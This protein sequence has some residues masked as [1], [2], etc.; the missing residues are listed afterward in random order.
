[1]PSF[2]YPKLSLKARLAARALARQEK[3][4]RRRPVRAEGIVGG[5]QAIFE[6]VGMFVFATSGAL[7]AIRKDFEPVG[8]LLLAEIT[9]VGGGVLRDLIIGAV[10]PQRPG[11]APHC[12]R[13]CD[14]RGGAHRRAKCCSTN[15]SAPTTR[16][17]ARSLT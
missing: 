9:A 1:M 13:V 15:T 8:I 5:M 11:S 2:S 7:M 3:E 12:G 4:R 14:A 16:P 17:G 6:L 10:Q